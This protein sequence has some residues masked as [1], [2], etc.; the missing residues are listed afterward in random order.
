MM[1]VINESGILDMLTPPQ[2]SYTQSKGSDTGGRPKKTI[3]DV[4]SGDG[5][6]STE[7]TIDSGGAE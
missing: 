4:A 1:H 3:D 7:A 5:G 6:E 2:T